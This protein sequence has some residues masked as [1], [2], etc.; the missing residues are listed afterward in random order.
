MLFPTSVEQSWPIYLA[1]FTRGDCSPRQRY[2]KLYNC[3]LFVFIIS[4]YQEVV[5]II[6]QGPSAPRVELDKWQL[7]CRLFGVS[8]LLVVLLSK[9]KSLIGVRLVIWLGM[10]FLATIKSGNW[11]VVLSVVPSLDSVLCRIPIRVEHFGD[12]ETTRRK[13]RV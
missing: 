10:L 11:R 2:V 12:V 13:E 6:F 9:C 5:L 7:V 1:A 8:R 4:Y 3:L